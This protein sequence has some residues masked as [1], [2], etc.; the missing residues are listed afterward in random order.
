MIKT[1]RDHY[2]RPYQL[3]VGRRQ[4]H[5]LPNDA[6]YIPQGHH[7]SSH[8]PFQAG[9]TQKQPARTE[10]SAAHEMCCWKTDHMLRRYYLTCKLHKAAL[11]TLLTPAYSCICCCNDPGL[12]AA[13]AAV[14]MLLTSKGY[15]KQLSASLFT[16]CCAL[17]HPCRSLLQ[18][19]R[20]QR[21]KELANN[22]QVTKV[23]I[24]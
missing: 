6:C 16:A 3:L 24:Y 12:L 10:G 17:S 14:H 1:L 11:H 19:A 5:L 21:Q 8:C 4:P 20:A 2:S 9:L 13:A 18:E 7:N 23:H 22:K 15:L